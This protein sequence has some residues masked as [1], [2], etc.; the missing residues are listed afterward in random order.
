MAMAARPFYSL[1]PVIDGLSPFPLIDHQQIHINTK[2]ENVKPPL[3]S[4][5]KPVAEDIKKVIIGFTIGNELK[6][7][8]HKFQCVSGH[9]K[10]KNGVVTEFTISSNVNGSLFHMRSL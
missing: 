3:K 4:E 5:E 8:I 6:C 9:S 7:S 2:T 10:I 1:I